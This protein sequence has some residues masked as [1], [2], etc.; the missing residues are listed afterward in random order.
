MGNG[1]RDLVVIGR[2]ANG[3]GGGSLSQ[4]LG[5][6]EVQHSNDSGSTQLVVDDTADQGHP[7]GLVENHQITGLSQGIISF[8][9]G[10]V[11]SVA[12]QDNPMD[13]ILILES[14]PNCTITKTY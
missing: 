10:Q 13:Q 5:N 6:V 14:D 1:W 8:V 9:P 7:F 4:I 2:T 3:S 12:I 11:S